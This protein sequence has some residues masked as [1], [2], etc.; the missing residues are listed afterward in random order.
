MDHLYSHASFIILIPN[1]T[2][3]PPQL[4]VLVAPP[5]ATRA[6]AQLV[7]IQNN[8]AYAHLV[9]SRTDV[10]K[11]KGLTWARKINTIENESQ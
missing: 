4:I 8:F 5:S 3:R 6:F 7:R 2:C 11:Q 1:E 10:S 9:N